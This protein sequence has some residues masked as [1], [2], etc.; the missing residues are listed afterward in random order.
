MEEFGQLTH[1]TAP[2][3]RFSVIL[4]SKI[5]ELW[6]APCHW[7]LKSSD[8][9]LYSNSTFVEVACLDKWIS[10]T[11]PVLFP[12]LTRRFSYTGIPVTRKHQK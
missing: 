12:T 3:T 4:T 6:V 10:K 11:I 8:G 7:N 1:S 5:G 2:R 9:K